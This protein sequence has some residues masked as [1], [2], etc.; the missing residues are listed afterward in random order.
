MPLRP[1][2]S[3]APDA[4]LVAGAFAS[5]SKLRGTRIV[6]PRGTGWS[7]AI[8]RTVEAERLPDTPLFRQERGVGVLR[9][10]RSGGL[11]PPLP[12]VLGIGMAIEL[13][14]GPPQHLLLSSS[15]DVPIVNRLLLPTRERSG[16]V[17]SSLLPYD[18]AGQRLLF[19]ARLG[20]A[21]GSAFA[22]RPG[23][24]LELLVARPLARFHPWATVRLEAEREADQSP[25]LRFNPWQCS[26]GIEPAGAINQLRDAA[27][28]GSQRGRGA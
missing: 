18:V 4:P 25:A 6:H 16:V 23:A 2:N 26:D 9:L 5:L 8:E 24:W 27:Y 12:D 14:D 28:Q 1:T 15:G 17:F 22:P 20:G 11:P 7:V 3:T 19:G 13:D 10:S 21:R